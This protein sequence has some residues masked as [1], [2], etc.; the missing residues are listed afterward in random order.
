MKSPSDKPKTEN[1]RPFLKMKELVNATSVPKSTIILYVNTGLLP[2]PVRTQRNMAYYHPSSVD[3]VGFIK[4]AQRRYRLPLKAIKGLLKEMDKGRDVAPLV[5][6]QTTLFGSRGR[7]MGTAAFCKKTGLSN[8]QVDAICQ[9]HLL[10][11]MGDGRFDA[12]DLAIGRL[13][14]KGLDLGMALSDLRF[15]PELAERMVDKEIS[16]RRKYTATL[17]YEKDAILTLEL[18][19]M[20]RSLRSY[21]IDRSMQKRLIRFKGLK[22]KNPQTG[23]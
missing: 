12:E 19:R 3:R 2:Q 17:A 16:L 13:L 4:H 22:N 1:G 7:Q 18:T 5:E 8:D 11:P 23:A 10:I 9:A 15:Y 21:V 14:K 20:A 6:L